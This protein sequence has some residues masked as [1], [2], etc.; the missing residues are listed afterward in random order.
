MFKNVRIRFSTDTALQLCWDWESDDPCQIP[1]CNVF[2]CGV[3]ENQL[4]EKGLYMEN[5]ILNYFNDNVVRITGSS[6][7][8]ELERYSQSHTANSRLNNFQQLSH[9]QE[10]KQLSIPSGTENCIFLVCIYDDNEMMF[11]A[12]AAGSGQ[13]VP[14]TVEQPGMLKKLFGGSQRQIVHLQCADNRKK[15]VFYGSGE[16]AI[17]AVL[18]EDHTTL[19]FSEDADLSNISIRY[20]SSLIGKN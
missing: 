9:F 19:Y 3:P 17:Y 1:R 5:E 4:L 18:P 2:Y 10:N 8:Q 16:R 6:V 7:R 20:L 11:R 13:T 12:V 15:A 14:F